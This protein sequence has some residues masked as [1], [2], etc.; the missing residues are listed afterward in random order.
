MKVSITGSTGGLGT[1]IVNTF[2]DCKLHLLDRNKGFDL[3]KN[4][5]DFVSQDF[6]V[7]I[8]NAHSGFR[9]TELL[10]KLFESNK[11]RNCII[12]NIGSVSSDGN[13]DYVNEYAVQKNA[14]EKSCLQ[15]QL[16]DSECKV[17][18]VKLGRTDTAMVANRKGYPKMDPMYIAKCIRWLVEQPENIVIK[19]LTVD[20]IH[21]NIVS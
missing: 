2:N 11:N 1:A 5:N 17:T 16:I 13:K 12:I 6:D 10:Y 19:N 7:F 8:N 18:L 20:Q 9:Q 4:L 3:D 14:L 21:S 15:L